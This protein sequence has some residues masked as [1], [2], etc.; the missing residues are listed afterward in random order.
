MLDM[1]ELDEIFY[2]VYMLPVVEMGSVLL[3]D[4]KCDNANDSIH[5]TRTTYPLWAR[6]NSTISD[7]AGRPSRLFTYCIAFSNVIYRKMCST[8]ETVG[9]NLNPSFN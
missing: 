8:V 9:I 2:I 3:C 7:D 4:D 5:K 1:L 6:W